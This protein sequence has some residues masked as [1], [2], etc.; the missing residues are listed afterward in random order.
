MCDEPCQY[1]VDDLVSLRLHTKEEETTYTASIASIE[2]D[3]IWLRN[4]KQGIASIRLRVGARVQIIT[5]QGQM[6]FS[7]DA[8]VCAARARD[9]KITRPTSWQLLAKRLS[10]RVQVE[11]PAQVFRSQYLKAGRKLPISARIIEIAAGGAQIHS[12]AAFH[13]GELLLLEF[14]LP[15]DERPIAVIGQVAHVLGSPQKTHNMP[16]K[17]TLGHQLGIRFARL[18]TADSKRIQAFIARRTDTCDIL[19]IP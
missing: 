3:G 4:P 13:T 11:W 7:A 1:A 17:I 2:T 19:Q 5:R 18:T 15:H 14:A 16:R 9:F 10:A 6:T 12:R 8:Q